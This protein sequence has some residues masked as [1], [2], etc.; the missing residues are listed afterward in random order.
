MIDQNSLAKK[1]FCCHSL[2]VDP[3]VH[4]GS[5]SD[6]LI[7]QLIT[8]LLRQPT[9]IAQP[10]HAFEELHQLFAFVL[11]GRGAG[12]WPREKSQVA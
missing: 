10:P 1:M 2:P 6:Q 3:C 5:D 12:N 8:A 9:P 7:R 4:S 11:F